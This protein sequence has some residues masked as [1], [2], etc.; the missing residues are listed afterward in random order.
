MLKETR[1][2]KDFNG[3]DVTDDFYFNLMPAEIA[4]LEMSTDKAV[5]LEATILALQE[6]KNS[7][8]I[9]AMFE[10]MIRMSIGRKSMR[11]LMSS[12]RLMLTVI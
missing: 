9:Y 4:R 10:K 2:Y 11:S 12:C 3:N 8:K 5:G 1:T 6:E 7:E